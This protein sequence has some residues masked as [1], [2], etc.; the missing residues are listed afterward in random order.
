MTLI[1]FGETYDY[2]SYPAAVAQAATYLDH[3]VPDWWDHISLA[4]LDLSNGLNCIGGQL[5]RNHP[6]FN[7]GFNSYY[8]VLNDLG[9]DEVSHVWCSN[10]HGIHEAWVDEITQRIAAR[11]SN[12]EPEKPAETP[13]VTIL[14]GNSVY[15]VDRSFDGLM[16]LLSHLDVD[17][18]EREVTKL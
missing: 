4:K 12:N 9:I 7:D 2:A 11:F 1:K 6:R 13:R 10:E 5:A 3:E 18:K 8:N 17:L 14:A 15:E 16:R